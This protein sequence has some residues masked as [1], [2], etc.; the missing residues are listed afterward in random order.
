MQTIFAYNNV[1][2]ASAAEAIRKYS[3]DAEWIDTGK[4]IFDYNL[5]I[6]SRWIG[7]EDLVVIEGDK[8]ITAEVI[9]SFSD[10]NDPWCSYSYLVYPEP[11]QK[12]VRVGLGCTKYSADLQYKIPVDSF[13]C[14]DPIGDKWVDCPDCNGTG[15]WR[16]LDT[17]ISLAI[18]QSCITFGP[19]VHGTINHHHEYPPDWAEQR[20]LS[21]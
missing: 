3:P 20:G 7:L 10:C 6:A 8:E 21:L 4:S 15:C 11:Y 12:S 9:P 14:N 13:I 19:H 5:A 1:P 18:L 17:R 2:N 16:F